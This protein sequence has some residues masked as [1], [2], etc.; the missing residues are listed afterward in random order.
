MKQVLYS[1]LCGALVLL[2][3]DICKADEVV[4]SIANWA[5]RAEQTANNALGLLG[6]L[7]DLPITAE[8]SPE[9]ICIDRYYDAAQ[10]LG[11]LN[12]CYGECQSMFAMMGMN[13]M[14]GKMKKRAQVLKSIAGK[15]PKGERY[16]NMM[17]C[18]TAFVI[19]NTRLEQLLTLQSHK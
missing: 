18:V 1:A 7:S 15:Q 12:A 2:A 3:A 11:Y 14:L 13:V 10:A 16:E 4:D 6:E 17:G 8:S 5:T 9:V 19:V